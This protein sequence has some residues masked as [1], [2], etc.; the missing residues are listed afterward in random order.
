MSRK[1]RG[2]QTQTIAANW[3]ASN[4]W[5]Y[6]TDAGAGRPGRDLLGLPGLACEVKARADFNPLAWLKQAEAS[7]DGDLPYVVWRANGYGPANIDRW[8]VMLRL[9]D[10][11]E[12]LHAAGYGDTP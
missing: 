1:Q 8:P 4:G 5:P 10:F 7:A 6:C 3:F 2:A 9:S 11:T 12:L